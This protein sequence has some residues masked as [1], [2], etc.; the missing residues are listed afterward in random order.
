MKILSLRL[1]NLNS[2]KGEF[3]IDFTAAPFKGN[4]LFAITGPT[5]AG[6][7]TLLDAI[8]LALYHRT[9]RMDSVTANSNELMTRHTADSL[10]E[11]VFEVKGVQYRAF[12]SQR[13][14]RDKADGALQPP[15]VELADAAGQ[16]LADKIGEKNRKIEDITGLS[17][18]RFTK[19]ML[20]AQGGFAAFLNAD[21]NAR[22]ELL[23]QLTG[24]DIYGQI[25]QRVFE[26][27]RE[28]RQQLEQLLARAEGVE[29]LSETQC[30]ELRA[31]A[32]ALAEQESLL[33]AD[34]AQTRQQQQ[35]RENLD[36]AMAA[37]QRADAQ[38]R[39]VLTELDVARPALAE[40]AASAPAEALRPLHAALQQA[41]AALQQTETALASHRSEQAQATR[42]LGT[43]TGR[44]L[45]L[46]RQIASE[47][48]ATLAQTRAA[49]ATLVE[50]R[51]AHAA[52]AALG[53]QLGLWEN[54]FA[55]LHKQAAA[56]TTLQQALRQAQADTHQLQAA[57]AERQAALVRE[58]QACAQARQAASAA[59]AQLAQLL[60]GRSE[61][62]LR[63]EWQRLQTREAEL[64][65]LMQILAE[66]AQLESAAARLQQEYAD[67]ET[68]HQACQGALEKQ[69]E[70]YKDLQQ[71]I[72]D[73][74]RLLEQEQRI[75]ALEAHRAQLQPHEACP[76][77]G[78]TEHPAIAAYQA[79]NLSATETALQAKRDELDALTVAGRALGDDF[80][81]LKATLA[82]LATQQQ[83]N[84]QALQALAQQQAGLCKALQVDFSGEKVIG[85]PEALHE[86]QCLQAVDAA[87]IAALDTL[88]QQLSTHKQ[89][90]QAADLQ[91]QQRETSCLVLKGEAAVAEERQQAAAQQ[92][93]T[94][95]QQIV[96][97]EATLEAERAQLRQALAQLDFA[98]PDDSVA[99]LQSR[100][101]DWAEWQRQE[102]RLHT[103]E[104]TLLR[105]EAQAQEADALQQQ[106][107]D[108]WQAL[109]DGDLPPASAQPA[110]DAALA[111]LSRDIA[112]TRRHLQQ[113]QGSQHALQERLA[114]ELRRRE[115]DDQAWRQALQRS[116]FAD[117]AAFIAALLPAPR[118]QELAALK[119]ALDRRQIEAAT[120]L[121]ETT[122][123][124]VALQDL[125]LTEQ[126][127]ATLTA[128]LNARG[129]QLR[130][131]TRRQGEI[132]HH[133]RTDESRR[134]G[135]AALFASIE[136][137][138]TDVD[139][140]QHLNGL[141]GSADGA[142]FR[143]YAQGLTLDHLVYLANQQLQ[144][145]HGRYVLNRRPGGELE[146]EIV[147]T[148]QGDLPRDTRTLS[149][150][151]SFL[152]SLA[153]ALALSDL[154]SH[155]TSIDSL[156][157]DEGFG[158]LDSETLEVALDAL[159]SLN[160]SGKMIGVISHI[161]GMKERIGVQIQVRKA[162]G[163]GYS[164]LELVG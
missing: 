67:T 143:K 127:L 64:R 3:S 110:P 111:T 106:W 30:L 151:E 140:W 8:C 6:K 147:D 62:G 128:E 70:R 49:I 48:A 155:K 88:Q 9:P 11:V 132:T 5:G 21:A 7:T 163:I 133:L 131:L 78:A 46:A 153:L 4:G 23:E 130:E 119:E 101:Q 19:S 77:C 1:K 12:W 52:H 47:K 60:N 34:I 50:Y 94:L 42:S 53:P 116:V 71:Q 43:D 26:R 81:A 161:E 91:L 103:Q 135:Q 109:G 117:E 66:Q 104:Q 98:W 100:R 63:L 24:T 148:W 162:A 82:L 83:T 154:V 134:Q 95:T 72:A 150:G 158:T 15:K 39:Q 2:I 89:L 25:S 149:G 80:G 146:L 28:A 59:H 55:S 54:Q 121:R 37:Q 20:L 113:L 137:K 86:L 157:L 76:L 40:L 96:A 33:Q 125:A 79:L 115:L 73:K 56:L 10:A 93:A 84:A 44:A 36:L 29:L 97:Q 85:I 160:A 142:K 22:A 41:G 123:A 38:Q 69:R 124:L 57:Q 17:F 107:Q 87:A 35:W 99:W 136:T 32:A 138:R 120:V 122:H 164:T 102:A 129:E 58:E 27:A 51:H 112:E 159:D 144:R 31:Q 114:Q 45:Q 65:Q 90:M 61:E 75:Q 139:L 126:D 13:R 156:F 118:R 16:I 14:A 68:R 92:A 108:E 141:I 74:Q 105:Q 145:L 18:E 152:V